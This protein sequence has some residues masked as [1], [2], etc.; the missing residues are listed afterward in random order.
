MYVCTHRGSYT[1]T[2]KRFLTNF[3]NFFCVHKLHAITKS[4]HTGAPTGVFRISTL[5]FF[6]TLL[7]ISCCPGMH[8]GTICRA[9]VR[10]FCTTYMFSFVATNCVQLQKCIPCV[11]TPLFFKMLTLTLCVL[12]RIH[13]LSGGVSVRP[14]TGVHDT[15]F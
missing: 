3:S 4:V 15:D 14:V 1:G 2:R 13:F 10:N 11:Y 8:P 6:S 9:Y 7:R 12:L 5:Y